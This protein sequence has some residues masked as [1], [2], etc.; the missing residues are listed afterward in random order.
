MRNTTKANFICLILNL[1]TL[2]VKKNCEKA[3][4]LKCYPIW[5][6]HLTVIE[7]FAKP[8]FCL[9]RIVKKFATFYENS[10]SDKIYMDLLFWRLN[11]PTI[12]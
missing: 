12:L 7:H 9:V 6:S 1:K 3:I 8:A 2:V 11:L 10:M 5:I 4:L